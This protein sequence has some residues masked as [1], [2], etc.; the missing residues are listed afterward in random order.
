[1][2]FFDTLR[3]VMSGETVSPPGATGD[4]L[5]GE[6][7]DNFPQAEAKPFDADAYDKTQWR[8]KL[9]R[10]LEELPDS[11]PEW[12]DFIADARALGFGPN[13][14][15][16]AFRDEFTLMVRRAVADRKFTEAEHRV[17][18]LA[19]DL[20][21]LPDEEAEV[22]LHKVVQEAESFFGKPVDGA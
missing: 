2:G 19:R 14:I 17:I 11:Q 8:K 1:M 13:W 18:D 16:R 5:L 9:K 21:G 12:E 10:I 7:T 3:K 15:H 22:I 6:E 20:M 4:G